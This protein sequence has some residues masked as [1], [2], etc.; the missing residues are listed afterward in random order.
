MGLTDHEKNRARML[1]NLGYVAFACDIYGKG[2]RPKNTDEAGVAAGKYKGD[3]AL[4]R[5]RLNLGL[6][7][8][9]AQAN[10]DGK[11]LGA[12]G[13][14]FGGTGALELARSGADVKAVVSFHGGLSTPNVE[15]AKN[16]KSKVLV[17]HGAVDPF[18]PPAEVAAFQKE[19]E[20]AK[21]DYQF[22]AYSGAKHSFTQRESGNNPNSPVA[23]DEKADRRSWAAMVIFFVEA[24]MK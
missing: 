16:M 19:M 13:Y 2:S 23:Y 4:F 21:V 24:F 1:A 18:V 7:Q 8:L 14:C 6:D 9:K 17:C 20:D 5:K 15:D 11:K 10:V 3:V 12:I 22:V